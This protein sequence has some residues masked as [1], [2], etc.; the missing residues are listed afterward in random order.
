[1]TAVPGPLTP[2]HPK[3]NLALQHV[4]QA[5]GGGEERQ[6]DWRRGAAAGGAHAAVRVCGRR[7]GGC[8]G[9]RG[10]RAGACARPLGLWLGEAGTARGLAAA[11]LQGL[12]THVGS[13]RSNGAW[14]AHSPSARELPCALPYCNP[15][16]APHPTPQLCYHVM[17]L[18]HTFWAPIPGSMK[19]YIATPKPNNYQSLH[20]TV[21]PAGPQGAAARAAGICRE[22]PPRGAGGTELLGPDEHLSY[23]PLGRLGWS[24]CTCVASHAGTPSAPH[25]PTH[26]A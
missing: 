21:G 8:N 19:D 15:N 12:A 2:P 22:A 16:R 3:P 23:A 18:V 14:H 7:F 25:P 6:G 17:G 4:A 11:R 1:M 10:G 24:A 26:P 13:E 20:T 5:A 9:R